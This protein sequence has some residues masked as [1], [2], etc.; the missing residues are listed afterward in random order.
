LR[1]Q[2][3]G[4]ATGATAHAAATIATDAAVVGVGWRKR[5]IVGRRLAGFGGE[6]GLVAG[7]LGL[8]GLWGLFFLGRCK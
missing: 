7:F 4:L 6:Q 8:P 3:P 2:S 5:G 1:R